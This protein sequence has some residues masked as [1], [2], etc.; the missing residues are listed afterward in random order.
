MIRLIWRELFEHEAT[1]ARI[2][3]QLRRGAALIA[4]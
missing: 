4:A 3:S 2:R 1:A